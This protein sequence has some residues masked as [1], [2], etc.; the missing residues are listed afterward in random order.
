MGIEETC[1]MIERQTPKIEDIRVPDE[2]LKSMNDRSSLS[3]VIRLNSMISS[4]SLPAYDH[5]SHACGSQRRHRRCGWISLERVDFV[6]LGMAQRLRGVPDRCH[7]Y[8]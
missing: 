4:N 7:P 2:N 6:P 8:P 5:S 3:E 1:N